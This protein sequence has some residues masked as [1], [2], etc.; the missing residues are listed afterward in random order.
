M[1]QPPRPRTRRTTKRRARPEGGDRTG[2]SVANE[3]ETAD[4]AVINVKL[5]HL[6]A[7]IDDVKTSVTDVRDEVQGIRDQSPVYR[8]SQL[9]KARENT[10]KALT[11]LVIAMI[12][13]WGGIILSWI[14]NGR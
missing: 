14:L 6:Q 2:E 4:V 1:T 10:R 7:S 12:V 3:V 9:E 13:T 5:D 8:I 11:G